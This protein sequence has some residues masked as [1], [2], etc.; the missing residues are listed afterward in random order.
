MYLPR[1]ENMGRTW[2][3]DVTGLVADLGNMVGFLVAVSLGLAAVVAAW[4]GFFDLFRFI[5]GL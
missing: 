3:Q 2:R 5:L 1:D 4:V